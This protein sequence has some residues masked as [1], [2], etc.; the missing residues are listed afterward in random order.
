VKLHGF[1]IELEDIDHHLEK[2]SYVKQATVVP[3][4]Q[5]H[6]VQQ[7]VAYVVANDNDFEKAYQLTK[8]VKEELAEGVMEYMIPQK[9]VYVE[10]LPLT[11]NGKIDRK[12]LINEVNR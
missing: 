12:R 5:D 8:A 1:R 10:Q 9:F 4:Y 11:A 7:L 2:V 6:K 3:K